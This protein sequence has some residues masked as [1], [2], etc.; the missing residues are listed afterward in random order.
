MATVS[1]S[2]HILKGLAD[3]LIRRDA[4]FLILHLPMI[5]F[6][7]IDERPLTGNDTRCLSGRD[8]AEAAVGARKFSRHGFSDSRAIDQEISRSRC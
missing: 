8:G 4:S 1:A 6:G 2:Q 5:E 7:R 3:S